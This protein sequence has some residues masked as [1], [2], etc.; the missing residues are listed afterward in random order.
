MA[1]SKSKHDEALQFLNA[2][3]SF[4]PPSNPPDN[5]GVSA[6]EGEAADVLA[7]LDEITQKSSEPTHP[8]S[9]TPASLAHLDRPSRTG[10]PVLKKSTER[11]RL[12]GGS[13]SSSTASLPKTNPGS[14][15]SDSRANPDLAAKHNS[16]TEAGNGNGGSGGW[17]WGSVWSTASAAI[18]QAKSVVDEQVKAL[19]NNEHARKWGE[20]VMEY[21]R[22]AQLDKLS[23][24][25]KRVGLSTLT[26]ILNVVAP[27]ISEHEVIRVWLSHDMQGY[28][29]VESLTYRSLSRIMEQVEGGDLVVNRGN[30][31]HP[32]AGSSKERDF[33][34]VDNYDA[35]LKLSEANVEEIVK[36][37]AKLPKPNSSTVSV[38]TTY[39]DV[40]IR[41]QPFFREYNTSSSHQIV[42][43][44]LQFLVYLADPEH[45]LAHITLTQSIPMRWLDMWD[46][47]DWVE[48]LTADVLRLG[49]DVIGQEYIAA[50]MGWSVQN[51]EKGD[52]RASTLPQQES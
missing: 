3:D 38:P 30:E 47:H 43:Q 27:P 11:V 45:K 6:P 44:D 23:E 35:A 17:G 21:A 51:E 34:A 52:G 25:F 18:K 48:D 41:V 26:D 24:D 40:Y 14:S 28:D 32:K 10:T 19:P 7:F 4:T 46:D 1:K 2:L 22:N 31:S 29:G 15:S 42:R 36:E 49:V 5:Q 33:N 8:R 9:S 13:A 50:R 37:N 16:S 12:G 39:S 20:G